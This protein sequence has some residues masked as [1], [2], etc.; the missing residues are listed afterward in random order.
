VEPYSPITTTVPC[1]HCDTTIYAVAE[2]CPHCGVRQFS[3]APLA[4]E[5][6]VLTTGLLCLLLGVFGA[7][8]FYTGKTGTGVLQLVT[9]GGAGL[10]TIFDLILIVTGQFR[11]AD[12]RRVTEWP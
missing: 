3:P 7:H 11:D 1:R 5:K 10:W 12:G 2:I 8:R 6:N 9:L 4:S